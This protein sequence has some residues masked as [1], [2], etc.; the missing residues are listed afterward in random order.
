MTSRYEASWVCVARA[1]S[2]F[3]VEQRTAV[4]G[5]EQPL[6]RVEDER[7]GLLEADVLRLQ[8]P[9]E[10]AGSAVGTVDVEPPVAALRQR[11]HPGEI[12][13]D[14]GVG[15][16]GGTDHGDDVGQVGIGVDRCLHGLARQTVVGRAD[17][18]GVHLQ[19]SEGVD[20]RGMRVLAHHHPRPSAGKCVTESPLPGL[21]GHRERRQIAGRPTGDE[22]S[23][24][25][26]RQSGLVGYQSQDAVLGGDRARCLEPGDA[27]D[28]RAG[29][30]HVEQQARLGRRGR[31]E[32]EEARAVRRDDARRDHRRV[33]AEDLVG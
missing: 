17:H 14:A 26:L 33:H 19:Q 30:E 23:A 18:Q 3:A 13:D 7:V 12:V 11:A 29:D 1:S 28:R 21:S 9:G 8:R 27:L 16:A 20:D 24:G 10:D 5:R 6:V 15:R 2:G 4:E 32:S 22:A 25:A 31:D